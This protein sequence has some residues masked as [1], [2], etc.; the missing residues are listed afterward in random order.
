M[1]DCF[2]MTLDHIARRQWLSIVLI[3]FLAF[4]GSAAIGLVIGIAEPRV[5]D[6]F[7]YLLAADTFAH[8]RLTNPTHPMWLHLESFHIIQRPSYMSKYPPAQGLI[9]AAGKVMGGHP[10]VGVWLSFGI[11]CAAICWM[12]HGWVPPRWALYGGLLALINPVVGVGTYWAQSYWGGAVAA[13]GGACV[14]GGVRRLTHERRVG[15]ALFTGVGLAILATSRPYEGLL[16]SIP[17]LVFLIVDTFKRRRTPGVG[18]MTRVFLP[19]CAVVLVTAIAMA[20]FHFRV[21]GHTLR[22]PYQIHEQSYATTPVFLWQTLPREPNYNHKIIRDFHER[23]ALPFYTSQQSVLGFLE[24][25]TASLSWLGL[26]FFNVFAVPLIGVF[27]L[28]LRWT[29]RNRW[30]RR[31][32][33]IYLVFM[34]GLLMET[35]MWDH[36]AAPVLGLNYFFILSAMRLWCRRD[37]RVGRLMLWLVALLA[38]LATAKSIHGLMTGRSPSTWHMQR[39]RLLSQMEGKEGKHLIIVSYGPRH[40]YLH[41]WVYNRADIDGAKVVW[42][43]QMDMGRNC[44]LI[45]YFKERHI[46]GLEID[47]DNSAPIFK[48]Y[49]TNLC[50]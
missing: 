29:W 43:R 18:S 2:V 50:R 16:L 31:A 22:M 38:T 19:I 13:T 3:G 23:Y 44:D 35:F 30:A 48:P 42:A 49:P 21:T 40:S 14:L 8:G 36:Y 15:H 10:I 20:F 9:F 27:T 34:V 7:S 39:A 41:E 28:L 5:H 25:K 11:M 26:R 32:M 47:E 1:K 24:N 4:A 17:T 46:W 12:L 37:R 45:E 6:E 33:L